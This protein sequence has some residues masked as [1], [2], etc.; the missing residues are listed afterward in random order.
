MRGAGQVHFNNATIV[1]VTN[2]SGM[3]KSP[4]VCATSC[5]STPDYVAFSGN[6][7]CFVQGGTTANPDI[8][9]KT[10]TSSTSGGGLHTGR[11]QGTVCVYSPTVCATTCLKSQGGANIYGHLRVG[12]TGLN[13]ACADGNTANWAAQMMIEGES[14]IAISFHDS[15][16]RIFA[17]MYFD[18]TDSKLWLGRSQG[19]S[20]VTVKAAAMFEA[21]GDITA[22]ASDCRMKCNILT[23]TCATD[24]I[25]ALRGVE[26]EWDKKYISDN[27]LSFEPSEKGKTTGFLAQELENTLPTAVREAPFESTL[28]RNASWAEK[29]KTVKA[30]KIIPLLVE[31]TKEQQ[32]TIEKQQQQINTLTCQVE[33]LLK[34]C[35]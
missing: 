24:R 6:G 19:W 14:D 10:S 5:I 15:G 25:K 22:Y 12:C 4:I 20:T 8:W 34:R 2:S 9:L 31:A 21:V 27:N 30:E 23:I 13:Q 18:T 28:C 1:E 33:M 32:C 7:A 35:A 11:I 16:E 29:Y 17:A 3:F 26:F